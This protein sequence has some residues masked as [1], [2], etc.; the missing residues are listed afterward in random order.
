MTETLFDTAIDLSKIRIE[1][2]RLLKERAIGSA[3]T[4]QIFVILFAVLI[5]ASVS[6]MDGFLW[7]VLATLLVLVTVLY[8]KFKAQ[9]GI[10][11]KNVKNY[12][13]GHVVICSFVGLLWGGFAIRI[14]DFSNPVSCIIAGAM[15]IILTV[16]GMLPSS[17]Y[18]RGYIALAACALLPF[19]LY[20]IFAAPD[21]LRYFGIGTLTYFGLA[22]VSSAQAE[23]NTRDGI[24]ARMTQSMTQTLIEKNKQVQLAH[25][26]KTQFLAATSHDFSQP[27]HAQGYYIEALG[28][29]VSTSEQKSLLRKIENSWRAQRDLLKGIAEIARIEN[30][31]IRPRPTAFSL[32]TAI[33]NLISDFEPIIDKNNIEFICLVDDVWIYSDPSLA[34][35]II[36]NLLDNAV[37]FTPNAGTVT[38]SSK[39]QGGNVV[40]SVSDTGPGLS[41]DL[42]KK[43]FDP[44]FQ[45][46]S[47]I[48]NTGSGLGL[49][50]VKRLCDLLNIE[51]NL[52]SD[53]EK[54]THFKL[55]FP[56]V[57]QAK[58]TKNKFGEQENVI[59]RNALVVLIDDVS[60]IR[61]AMTAELTRIGIQVIAAESC[62]DAISVLSNTLEI[63]SLFIIDKRLNH[64][65]NGIDAI[66]VLREEVNDTVPVILMTGDIKG[67]DDVRD[68]DDVTIMIKPI[69]PSE[70]RQKINVLIFNQINPSD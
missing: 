46:E 69:H 56:I 50:I 58:E 41:A 61:D 57:N 25:D 63:P 64:G 70:L 36:R 43:I 54:G 68:L 32:K 13:F 51:I 23:I 27:L 6:I 21:G 20:L 67:F 14:L 3:V 55:T 1:Q 2:A 45:V 24:I 65:E 9:K 42:Q 12:L 66:E 19:A 34:S 16:G 35:R 5:G 8:A 39:V 31:A 4:V 28:K 40:V 60:A 10:S 49:S 30:G 11:D 17:A 26:E 37:K 22:M 53:V 62:G 15:P 59:D 52:E 38:L 47:N 48:Q 29:C 44:Y 33:Q 7:L 18:R